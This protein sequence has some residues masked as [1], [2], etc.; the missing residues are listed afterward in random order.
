MPVEKDVPERKWWWCPKWYWPFAVCSSI[1]TTHKW[2]YSFSWVKQT[3]YGVVIHNE[4]CENGKLYTWDD[5]GVGVGDLG[6]YVPVGEMCFDSSRSGG[7]RCDSSNTGIQASGLSASDPL[8]TNFDSSITDLESSVVEHGIF[9]FTEETG[10]LCQRG[11]WPWKR[12]LH[13]QRITVSVV[14]RFATIRWY[15]NGTLLLGVNGTVSFSAFCTYP[16]PLPSGRNQNQVVN[17]KYEIITEHNKSTLYLFNDPADG[18]YPVPIEMVA[19]DI[20]NGN[21]FASDDT[22]WNF[23]G[24]TCDFD[25]QQVDGMKKCLKRFSDLSKDKALSKKPQPGDPIIK[26]GDEISKYITEDHR[27]IVNILLDIIQY[28]WRDDPETFTLAVNQLEIEIGLPGGLARFMKFSPK[29]SPCP[30]S[31]TKRSKAAKGVVLLAAGIFAGIL[32]TKVLLR[33][34]DRQGRS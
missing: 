11:L 13:N 20:D 30:C 29:Q 19:V 31:E 14:T 5:F 6:T 18:C 1:R 24:E 16:F 17:V 8:A 25:P 3:A 26:I 15:V 4:G 27:D 32:L 28:S 33:S 22:S 23:K 21:E 12:T 2:C 7:G 34:R 10:G 9:E